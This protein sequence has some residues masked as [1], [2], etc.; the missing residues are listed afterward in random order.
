MIDVDLIHFK[1][2]RLQLTNHSKINSYGADQ[3]TKH[4]FADT[5]ISTLGVCACISER[6]W[7]IRAGRACFL[8]GDTEVGQFLAGQCGLLGFGKKRDQLLQALDRFFVLL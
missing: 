2:F 4:S 1:I 8:E 5:C 3:R 6:R 7:L